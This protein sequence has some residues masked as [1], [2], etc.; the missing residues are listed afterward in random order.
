[1]E[2]T[3]RTTPAPASI[4]RAARYLDACTEPGSGASARF[5][6]YAAVLGLSGAIL[7]ERHGGDALRHADATTLLPPEERVPVAQ[8][9]IFDLASVTKLFTT[10]AA[11]QL[12]EEGRLHLD[13]PGATVLPAFAAHGKA[14]VTTRHLLTHTSGLEAWLPLWSAH[15]DVQTRLDAVLAAAPATPPGTSRTYSDLN[16]ITV[17]LLV[18]AIRGAPLDEV[19]AQ[20]I[21]GPL[22]M[23]DTGYRPTDTARVAATEH[24]SAPPRGM[25]RGEVHDENAWALGGVAGH[26]GLFSTTGDLAVL[27]Q[28]LLD[29]GTHRGARILD[30]SSVELFV[31]DQGPQVPG[32]PQGLGFELDRPRWMGR[33]ASPRTAGHTGFTGTSVVLDFRTRAFAILLT[34]RVHPVRTGGSIHPA[35]RAWADALADT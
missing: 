10:I 8:D 33:L 23:H 11:V 16:L 6:G 4:T 3:R 7:A 2:H 34:N 18:E 14:H 1:M 30:P 12:V 25:V 32:E 5:P 26:A 22:G 15:P 29:G 13:A 24:Q 35:R 27:A 28:T 19:V 20:R 9:T 17:G 21:T 31:T